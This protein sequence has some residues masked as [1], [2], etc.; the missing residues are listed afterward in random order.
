MEITLRPELQERLDQIASQSGRTAGQIV[1]QLVEEF[2]DHDQWFREEVQKG[3]KELDEGEFI[4]HDDLA[5]QIKKI[6]T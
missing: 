3:L 1:Q 4:L 2:L 6:F 5:A